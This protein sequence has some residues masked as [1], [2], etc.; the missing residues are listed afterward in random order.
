MADGLTSRLPDASWQTRTIGELAV[1]IEGDEKLFDSRFRSVENSIEAMDRRWGDLANAQKTAVEALGIA[2]QKAT[3][4]AFAASQ[5]AVD[6]AESYNDE[7]KRN[8]NEWKDKF[9]DQSNTMATRIDLDQRIRFMNEKLETIQK[10][11]E[12]VKA[13]G[14]IR[15]GRDS[16]KAEQSV[17]IIALLMLAAA[18]AGVLVH[19]LWK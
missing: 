10:S 16:E 19:L 12:P 9:D 7:W 11:I 2:N 14:D 8:S 3:D 17:Y 13:M 5:K 4:A 15:T 18:V 1:R 6:K